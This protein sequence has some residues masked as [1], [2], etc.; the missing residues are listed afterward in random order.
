MCDIKSESL[1]K[2][3]EKEFEHNFETVKCKLRSFESLEKHF[4]DQVTNLGYEN[5]EDFE[6]EVWEDVTS[7]RKM[8]DK[9]KKHESVIGKNV[10]SVKSMEFV[11]GGELHNEIGVGNDALNHLYETLEEESFS[12]IKE[13]T[14]TLLNSSKSAGGVG[15]S[16]GQ[17]HGG[18]YNGKDIAKIFVS[19][20]KIIDLIP[21][22]FTRKIDFELLLSILNAIFKTTRLSR[23]LTVQERK[24]LEVNVLNLST[25]YHSAFKDKAITLK[26]HDVLGMMLIN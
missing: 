5:V 3:G 15:C 17:A 18:Q 10:S 12:E 6:S 19:H 2:H 16:P 7:E 1:K 14:K 24:D 4:S 13:E 22:S 9:G 21:N 25:I 23:F 8:R 26:M 11:C 20:E